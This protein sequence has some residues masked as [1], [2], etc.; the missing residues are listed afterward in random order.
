M[1]LNKNKPADPNRIRPLTF[2][3]SPQTPFAS[4]TNFLNKPIWVLMLG[5]PELIVPMLTCRAVVA[6]RSAPGAS[7]C[8]AEREK[9]VARPE[10]KPRESGAMRACVTPDLYA[11]LRELRLLISNQRL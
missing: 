5:M 9:A 2:A 6:W 1:E 8:G 3:T 4:L 10:V 11:S 7:L